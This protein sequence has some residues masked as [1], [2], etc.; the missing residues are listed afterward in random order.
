MLSGALAC[1][2]VRLGFSTKLPNLLLQTNS[3]VSCFCQVGRIPSGRH[4]AVD[5]GPTSRLCSFRDVPTSEAGDGVDYRNSTIAAA[6]S[7]STWGRP[8][9]AGCVGASARPAPLP[10][11]AGLIFVAENVASHDG[12]LST[13][14]AQ[15]EAVSDNLT[16]RTRRVAWHSAYPFI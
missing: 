3:G 14:C 1:P 15:R 13:I 12:P 11:R 16:W 2:S 7:A 9:R 4:P 8:P 10:T 6:A 5:K